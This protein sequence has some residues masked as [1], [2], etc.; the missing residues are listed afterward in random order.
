[1]GLV[2]GER[3]RE[4]PECIV[5]VRAD[6]GP[7]WA[8][9]APYAWTPAEERAAL[10]VAAE[11]ARRVAV[12]F[13]VIDVAQTTDGAWIVIERNDAQESGY[14]GVSP[15]ALWQRV[16]ERERARGEGAW[17][18]SFCCYTHVADGRRERHGRPHMAHI[19]LLGDSILDNG[20]Y[21]GRGQPVI[22][23]VRERLPHAWRATLLAR[24]GSVTRDVHAQLARLPPDASH[25]VISA[26]GNDA[27]MQSDVVRARADSVGAALDRLATIGAR[28]AQQ[29]TELLAQVRA[30]GLPAT[31]CTIYDPNMGDTTSQRILAAGLTIFNDVITRAAFEGGFGLIDLRTICSSPSDYANEI[32]PSSAGGAKIA[33]AIVQAA[34]GAAGR[35]RVFV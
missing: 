25:L 21:V 30:R 29:Y 23:Q 20:A 3:L 15:F 18:P 11:A 34:T 22:A 13:L 2:G 31:V 24:D 4:L 26:G 14:A 32:E 27:L 33:A 12:P 5:G 28:F 17:W 7:Y 16:I 6:A 19:I 10:A 35:S 8:S 1:V 9:F